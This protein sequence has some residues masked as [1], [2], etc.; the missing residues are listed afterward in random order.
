MIRLHIVSIVSAVVIL[1][2]CSPVVPAVERTSVENIT[3]TASLVEE[4][5]WPAIDDFSAA[6]D[7]I[8]PGENVTLRWSVSGAASVTIDNG[9]GSVQPAGSIE[10]SPQKTTRYTLTASGRKGVSTAWVTVEVVDRRTFMPDLVI[11]GV[12]HISGLLYYTVRNIGAADAGPSET[13]V[14]DP[15]SYTHLTLPTIYSV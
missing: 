6:A 9:L 8:R 12:T 13:Y 14:Y 1:A 7:L 4:K 11:T 5:N 3:P 10:V 15:V 2:G